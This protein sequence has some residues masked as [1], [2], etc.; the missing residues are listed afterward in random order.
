MRLARRSLLCLALLILAISC[1]STPKARYYE[2]MDMY[3]F[4]MTKVRATYETSTTAEQEEMKRDL[5][6]VLKT[7]SN[8]NKVWKASLNDASKEQAVML[9]WSEAK[10][11]LL[12][13]GIVKLEEVENGS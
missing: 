4:V 3:D 10:A 12:R 11:A 9:A 6:P 7:W 1:A 13:F 5:L 8:A 2:N